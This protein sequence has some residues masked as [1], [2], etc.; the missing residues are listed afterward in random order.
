LLQTRRSKTISKIFGSHGKVLLALCLTK[1]Y[2][3]KAYG[4]VDV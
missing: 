1:N 4:R 3:M 2:T